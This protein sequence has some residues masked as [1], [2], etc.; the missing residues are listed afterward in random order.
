MVTRY[1]FFVFFIS[2]LT[3]QAQITPYPQIYS[4]PMDLPIELSGSFSE[5]RGDHFHT[6][7]DIR[8][9]HR[10]HRKVYSIGDGWVSRIKVEPAGYGNALYITHPEGYVSVYA[11]LDSFKVDHAMLVKQIQ[12]ARQSFFI[13]V[14]FPKDTLPVKRGEVIGI[15]GNSGYSFGAHL[16]FEIRDEVSEEPIDPL[17]FGITVE[18]VVVPEFRNL[19][20]YPHGSSTVNGKSNDV[21][22]K[23]AKQSSGKYSLAVIPVVSGAVSFGF[24][25]NDKQNYSNPNRLGL[26]TLT[27]W[28]DDSL[29]LDIR[30]ERLNFDVVKH[31]LAFIDYPER[32]RSSRRF[33][34]TWKRP[35]N[36]LPIYHF[37]RDD[38]ILYLS[39]NRNYRIK[40]VITDIANHKAEL[41]FSLKSIP[42]TDHD[43]SLHCMDG[44][45]LFK[46]DSL[47][48]WKGKYTEV[49]I[50]S[51]AMFSDLCFRISEYVSPLS[52]Y[53]P[54]IDVVCD[55]AAP[56]FFRI[57][58]STDSITTDADDKMVIAKIG[59]N[60]EL[61]GISTSYTEKYWEGKT[62]N[63]GTFVLVMDTIPP[64]IKPL[65]L[66]TTGTVSA[67]SQINFKV[68]DDVSGIATYNAWIN[69]EWVLLEYCLKD[70]LMFYTIDERM[71]MG[72]SEFKVVI[73]DKAG[74]SSEW[75]QTLTR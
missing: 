61:S 58:F 48:L 2:G 30:F 25:V 21:I 53:A 31:Q 42:Q 72:E 45:M 14:S 18:D 63:F 8:V 73:T 46:R 23:V 60:N 65:W 4:A 38:G 55:D 56:G 41:L 3:L 1:V 39:E 40:C 27:V 74:N 5:L 22:Y 10:P 64:E 17:L 32:E 35:G 44:W 71:P 69:G 67:L 7:I 33:Q 15:A 20:I 62:R 36:H 12:Y 24:E 51:A 13:D 49:L 19:K 29:F 16:H 59:E 50:D 6:G 68:T 43:F 26:K 37:I 9:I 47:N 52:V 66:P 75:K 28:V 70:D 57:R 11:H 54:A 34:R